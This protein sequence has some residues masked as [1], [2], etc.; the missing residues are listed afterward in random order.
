M[1]KGPT[2]QCNLPMQDLVLFLFLRFSY[3]FCTDYFPGHRDWIQLINTKSWIEQIECTLK[4][5]GFK[6]K[7]YLI[8]FILKSGKHQ[9]VSPKWA[10][11]PLCVS[12]DGAT[13][14]F[15]DICC[16]ASSWTAAEIPICFFSSSLGYFCFYPPKIN[17]SFVMRAPRNTVWGKHLFVCL[18]FRPYSVLEMKASLHKIEQ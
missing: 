5:L 8:T 16:S 14:R 18:F 15:P 6:F 4:S 12:D 13:S 1:K 2:I 17:K 11:A 7:D 10:L 3:T 9:V